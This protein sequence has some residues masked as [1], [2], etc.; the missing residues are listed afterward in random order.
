[1][2]N[3]NAFHLTTTKTIKPDTTKNVAEAYVVT[4]KNFKALKGVTCFALELWEEAFR[5]PH[6]HPN[7]SELGY[8]LSGAVEVMIWRSPGESAVFTVTAGMCW[9]IPLAALHS[10]NNIGRGRAQLLVGFSEAL[11]GDM[12]LPVAF[13]GIPAPVRDA[14]TSPHKLLRE[15]QGPNSNPLVGRYQPLP[16]VNKVKLASPYGFDLAQTPPLFVNKALGSVTWAVK[17][18]WRILEGI[19]IL[20]AQLKSGTARD[21]IWYP[22]AGTLYV[23]AEGSGTFHIITANNNNA[24]LKINYLDYIYVPTGV[25]HTFVNTT[26]KELHLIAF[27]TQEDPQP[28]VSLSVA[29]GFFPKNIRESAMRQYGLLNE[30]GAELLKLKNTTVSPYILKVED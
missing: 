27:F 26:K 18:N 10:L 17:S 3:Q 13:N 23:V 4:D 24:P 15:W 29:T 30:K 28:E 22:D 9:F 20:R 8:V 14:L 12:D 5:L 11:P 21:P 2:D 7:A 25:L 6:W 19:S 1:M 16:E